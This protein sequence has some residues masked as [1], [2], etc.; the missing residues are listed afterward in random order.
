MST[1]S[2]I[3]YDLF[4]TLNAIFP[5]NLITGI[6]IVILAL[7]VATYV[8]RIFVDNSY[9]SSSSLFTTATDGAKADAL[10]IGNDYLPEDE[11][12]YTDY[13]EQPTSGTSNRCPYC[14]TKHSDDDRYCLSCGGQL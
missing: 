1:P 4:P 13:I 2:F 14:N 11:P 5:L 12:E 6:L 10:E 3:F 8:A 9:P 7:R